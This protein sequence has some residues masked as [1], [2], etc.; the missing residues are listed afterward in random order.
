MPTLSI[1]KVDWSQILYY[2]PSDFKHPE[3]LDFSVVR[4]LDR[5]A[6]ML[7]RKAVILSDFRVGSLAP[8]GEPSVHSLGRA[9]DFTYPGLDPMTVL[10]NIQVVKCFSGYGMYVNAAGVFSFH[11]DTRTSR[12]VENPATWGASKD[13]ATAGV[14]WNY[15]T[16]ASIINQ[17]IPAAIPAFVWMAI[18]GFGIYWL[19]KRT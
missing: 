4:G 5:L 2:E 19:A 16:L 12:T 14:G 15:K 13:V 11:V 7:G 10:K 18:M 8:S 17:Y 3:K 1:T 6:A 9:I